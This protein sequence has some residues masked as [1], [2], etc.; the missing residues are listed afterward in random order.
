[1]GGPLHRGSRLGGTPHTNVG[2]NEPWRKM[3]G[4]GRGRGVT[5]SGQGVTG[6]GQE[7][8][9]PKALLGQDEP[10]GQR[11]FPAGGAGPVGLG[12][13]PLQVLGQW[14]Q[15]ESASVHSLRSAGPGHPRPSLSGWL[16]GGPLPCRTA[17]SPTLGAPP[18]WE[19]AR[20]A[21]APSGRNTEVNGGSGV[22]RPSVKGAG[23]EDP[24]L[25]R[26]GWSE[27]R[28]KPRGL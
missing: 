23:W 28:S 3:A 9:H 27:D 7:E 12:R 16:L 13:V 20:A 8:R 25:F 6:N 21:A 17:R 26:L 11:S 2:Q 24:C 15:A 19:L 5:G 22:G 10:S 14:G 18:P 1:M 4:A